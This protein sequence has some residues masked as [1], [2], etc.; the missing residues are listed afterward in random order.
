[1]GQM[2]RD[3]IVQAGMLEAGRDDSAT[4]AEGWL[5]RWLDSVAASWQ[6]PSLQ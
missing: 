6:W 3:Q 2:T 4:L 5:Q 1:M